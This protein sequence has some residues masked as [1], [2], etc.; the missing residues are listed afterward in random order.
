ML[1]TRICLIRHGE[2]AWNTQY[3][4]Q[5]HADIP[6]NAKGLTQAHAAATALQGIEPVAIYH[7]DLQ[8]AAVTA[9][10]IGKTCHAPL[11]PE[12][13]LRERHFGDIQGLT[14]EEADQH[15]PGLYARIRMRELQA[16]PP[17]NGE[18]LGAFAQRIGSAFHTIAARHAGQVVLIVSHGGCMDIM[19]RIVT[20]KSLLEPRDFPLGN[21]TLN[22]VS[23]QNGHWELHEWDQKSHLSDS[24]DEISR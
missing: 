1:H 18:S 17:G 19:Y 23:W 22:W 21:A 14:R 3:R 10:I 9:Q 8:R 5:G 6:L 12:P 16:E 13:A 20:G 2:T 24:F 7:S 4:L 15:Y 11:H